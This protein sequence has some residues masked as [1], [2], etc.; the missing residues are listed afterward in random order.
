[1]PDIIMP[2]VAVPV[3]LARRPRDPRG[4][5][6]PFFVAW[7]SNG[8]LVTEPD[9]EPDFRVVDHHRMVECVKQ[10]KCWLCGE[11][12][13][14]HLAFVL[15]PM[16]TINKVISE[17]PSH[18][19]CAEYALKVCPFLTRPR[20]RRNEKDLPTDHVEA[21]GRPFERNPG[22]SAMWITRSYRPFKAHGGNQ[23][24]LF[25]VGPAE[26]VQWWKEGRLATR[27]E[28]MTAL[29]DGYDV[30]R[31]DAEQEGPEALRALLSML[32]EAKLTL[33]AVAS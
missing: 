24:V 15:G 21:A 23:G 20:M 22:I 13:G 4:F 30:L 32:R 1:M 31:V 19:E 2:S 11:K 25:N 5:I 6:I 29:D 8:K 17:P 7:M 3:R 12:L 9:G 18:R 14:V 33:P 10:R 16:C 28:A 26:Q 27:Q